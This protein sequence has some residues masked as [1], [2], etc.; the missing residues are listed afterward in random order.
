MRMLVF[1]LVV[2]SGGACGGSQQASVQPQETKTLCC[3][4]AEYPQGAIEGAHCCADGVWHGDIGNGGP[5][6]CDE[7]G[8]TGRVCE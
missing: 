6:E 8:G 5:D 1:V 3:P 4:K 2:A 7:V